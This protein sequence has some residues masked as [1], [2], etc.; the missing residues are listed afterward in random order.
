[1]KL[2]HLSPD[3]P[4]N[5]ATAGSAKSA[6][7]S[8]TPAPQA[9]AP[10]EAPAGVSVKL[11]PATVAMINSAASAG[12]AVFNSAKVETMRTAIE[13]G[14]FSVNAEAI[15]DKMLANAAEMIG[16]AS[17]DRGRKAS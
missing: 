10:Q 9:T 5:T 4:V 7:R 12:P 8:A 17:G 16:L 6:D 11:G 15:A 1:M 3:S 2:N 14:T 13:N